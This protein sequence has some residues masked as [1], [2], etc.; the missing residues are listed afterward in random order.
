MAVSVTV[1]RKV[2]TVEWERSHWMDEA[3]VLALAEDNPLRPLLLAALAE[4]DVGTTAVP[5]T[6]P[7]RDELNGDE[8]NWGW[9]SSELESLTLAEVVIES[10]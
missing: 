5:L 7:I 8:E 2:V 10:D 3:D 1:Y 9:K 4:Q 6:A